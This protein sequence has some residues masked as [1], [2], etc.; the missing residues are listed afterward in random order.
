MYGYAGKILSVDLTSNTI[1]TSSLA[2]AFLRKNLGGTGFAANIYLDLIEGNT[3]FDALDADNPFVIMTGP[4]T[5]MKLNGVA[6]WV[7]ATRSPLTGFWA[8]ANIGGHFGAH[9]KFAG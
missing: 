2:G 6:R 1:K 3:R 8:D 5:G 9:L 7:C 4:L